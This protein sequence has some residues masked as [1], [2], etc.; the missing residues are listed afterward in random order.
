MKSLVEKKETLVN[1]TTHAIQ[2]HVCV[3]EG[4]WFFRVIRGVAFEE[5]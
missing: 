2:I 1:A 5:L 4:I 3:C